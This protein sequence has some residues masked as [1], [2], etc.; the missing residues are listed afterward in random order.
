[1]HLNCP[2]VLFFVVISRESY[3]LINER[4]SYSRNLE[5]G[6]TKR[7]EFQVILS[8]RLGQLISR[9]KIGM[10]ISG[11]SDFRF[12]LPLVFSCAL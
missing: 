2:A 6:H 9:G 7:W 8:S 4:G 3:V 5:Q 11:Q 10:C 12:S 1:V